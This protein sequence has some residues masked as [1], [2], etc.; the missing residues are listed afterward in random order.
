MPEIN[1]SRA[2]KIKQR[3]KRELESRLSRLSEKTA[4]TVRSKDAIHAQE[5]DLKRLVA[6]KESIAK[7]LNNTGTVAA[8]RALL[9]IQLETLDIEVRQLEETIASLKS[10]TSSEPSKR[11][12]RQ[13]HKREVRIAKELEKEQKIVEKSK[14]KEENYIREEQHKEEKE[15]SKLSREQARHAQKQAKQDS[16]HDGKIETTA[17]ESTLPEQ[18]AWGVWLEEFE[19]GSISSEDYFNMRRDS[20]A[21]VFDEH[22]LKPDN[23]SEDSHVD[24]TTIVD[25]PYGSSIEGVPT[26]DDADSASPVRTPVPLEDSKPYDISTDARYVELLAKI[27]S[28]SPAGTPLSDEVAQDLK[29]EEYTDAPVLSHEPELFV[30]TDD[31]SEVSIPQLSDRAARKQERKDAKVEQTRLEQERK[32]LAEKERQALAADIEET[33]PI[34]ERERQELAEKERQ[35]IAAAIEETKA[36]EERERQELA[37]KERQ[38]VAAAKEETRLT[39]QKAKDAAKVEQTR[40]EQ[41][42][43]ELA[44]KER[45]AVAA[46]KEAAKIEETRLVKERKELAEKERQAVAAAKEETRVEEARLAEERKKTKKNSKLLKKLQRKTVK[47]LQKQERLRTKSLRRNARKQRREESKL[48]RYKAKYSK[49]EQ[50]FDSL[51]HQAQ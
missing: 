36:I 1:D 22:T 28:I 9:Q 13:Q 48:E 16:K 25:P 34:E 15:Q 33:K 18:E 30:H 31:V 39:A 41:E 40:L 7:N 44:E 19:K 3:N 42:R 8:V 32:E 38:A 27:Q 26:L 37:E 24:A 23:L 4:A 46:A 12:S 20:E 49:A 11:E 5:I 21:G 10:E 45:Q 43:K 6:L 14:I 35:A 51:A 17:R 47:D 29:A 50:A 2:E